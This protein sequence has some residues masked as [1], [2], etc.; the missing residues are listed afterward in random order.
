MTYRV[1][2]DSV[3]IPVMTNSKIAICLVPFLAIALLTPFAI[4]AQ[5]TPGGE[6]FQEVGPVANTGVDR[7]KDNPSHTDIPLELNEKDLVQWFVTN[8]DV[9][10]KTLAREKQDELS[11]ALFPNGVVEKESIP[12]TSIGYD[13]K[14]NALEVTIDPPMFTDEN[15]P[16][17]IAKIRSIVGND[18][19]VTISPAEYATPT[20]C[21]S[22]TGTC[23]PLKGGVEYGSSGCTV[24][25]AATYQGKSGFITAG[26]CVDGKTGEDIKQPIRGNVVGEVRREVYHGY[27]RCDCAFISVNIPMDDG[28]FGLIDPSA[29]SNPFTGMYVKKSGVATG[30]TSGSVVDDSVNIAYSDGTY[31]RNVVKATYNSDRGDSGSPVMSG[32]SLVGIHSAANTSAAYFSNQKYVFTYF[33]GLSWGF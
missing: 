22:R 11:D 4:S 17:Y 6:D 8:T 27:T 20:A 28:I 13:Y 7:I 16:Q 31:V 14:D 9:E 12:V 23:T 19:D 32:S 29:T 15:I 1:I 30:V 18:I 33:G 24:G 2:Y 21:A 25:F 3:A 10:K 26:H 5:T